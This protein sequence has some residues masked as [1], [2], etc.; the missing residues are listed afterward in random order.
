MVP[1]GTMAMMPRR[2][3]AATDHAERAAGHRQDHAFGEQ[4]AD[5]PG[6]AAPREA[7]MAISR[8]RY[9]ARESSR[10]D[11]LTQAMTSSRPTAPKRLA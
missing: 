5:Q 8:L 2:P 1:G 7:R 9:A 11:T 6:A 10:L 4:L 3:A